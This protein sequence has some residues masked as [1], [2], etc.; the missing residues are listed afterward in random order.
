MKKII[1]SLIIISSCILSACTA[2]DFPTKSNITKKDA[3]AIVNDKYISKASLV[4]LEQ[5]INQGSSNHT[6]SKEKL[7]EELIQRELLIQEALNKQLDKD[8][9]YTER[10]QTIKN[11]L[12]SQ[13]AIQNFL[14]SNPVTDAELE[15]EYDKNI[16]MAAG[17]EYKARHILLKS[18]EE[19]Q[20]IIK[21]LVAGADFIALA[22]AKS[23]GSS[24]SQGGDLGWFSAAQMVVPFS[25]ATIALEYGKFS[26]EPVQTQFG[27]HIILKEDSRDLTPPSFESVKEKIRSTVQREKIQ[28]FMGSLR[29]LAEVEILLAKEAEVKAPTDTATDDKNMTESANKTTETV[30]DTKSD[31][32]EIQQTDTEADP[33]TKTLETITP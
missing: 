6:F 22:K 8:A 4:Q 15:A 9:E 14:K 5:E 11:S 33:A 16:S 27:W 26:T 28:G 23:I 18:E 24:A 2:E 7:I 31:A 17:K 32:E 21:E 20:A 29:K 25:E 30:I 19:A 1:I 3:I 13:A 12:L 10:L